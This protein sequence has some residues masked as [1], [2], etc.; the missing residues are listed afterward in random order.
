MCIRDRRIPVHADRPDIAYLPELLQL[1]LE[2]PYSPLMIPLRL[3]KHLIM[4]PHLMPHPLYLPHDPRTKRTSIPPEIIRRPY[5]RLCFYPR[6]KKRIIRLPVDVVA[7][8]GKTRWQI[9]SLEV[10]CKSQ[11]G[12]VLRHTGA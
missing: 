5:S 7:H 3:P 9:L 8:H 6:R 12:V 11:G 1:M 2:H 10:L 4:I